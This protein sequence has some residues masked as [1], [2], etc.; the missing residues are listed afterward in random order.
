LNG[1]TEKQKTYFFYTVCALFIIINSLLIA[2]EFFYFSFI[3]FVLLV[4]FMMVY[5]LDK[6]LLL[7][8]FLTPLA[9]RI[10]NPDLNVTMALPTEPMMFAI[11][12]LFIIKLFYD[13]H[14]FDSS[15]IRHPVTIAII[16]NLLWIFFTSL[17]S[18]IPIVSFKFLTARLW[19]V[20]SFFFFGVLLFKDYSNIKRF[21]WLF[22]IPLAGVILYITAQH[23]QNGFDR[24]VGTWIVRPFFNDHTA[25]AAVISLF[26]P[27]TLAQVFNSK[28]M[29]S[30][31]FIALLIF[32]ILI[33]G[34]LLSYSRAG[35]VSLAAAFGIFLILKFKIDYKII[36]SIAVI[37]VGLFF[38]FKTEIIME[39][40]KN[41]QDSSG[42]YAEHVRSISNIS[43]DA[44]NLERLNRWAAAMRM[45]K[46]KPIH[47][48]GPGTYQLVYAP[49]QYSKERTVISTNA[50]DLGN[51]HS[52]Y[53]GPLSESGLPGMI[54]FIF[55]V[56]FVIYTGLKVYKRTPNPE[57]RLLSFGLLLG[58][59]T[60]FTH[61][62]MN[63]FLDTDK[64]SV[65]FWAMIAI[66]VALD[67]YHKDKKY[68][69][70]PSAKH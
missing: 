67:I 44:S 61:G 17:T 51:A 66:L 43:T 36:F 42:Q 62:I 9:V 15:F 52:E 65:P 32:T 26:I 11:L 10:G 60:Y 14:L 13:R 35:W 37:L 7:I 64:A 46:E 68:D 25:Y 57:V 28:N 53:I 48:W 12:L 38:I 19:F 33:V 2:Q 6:L 31:R 22:S 58:L 39:L 41:T 40:E 30:L 18:V 27:V 55:I 3:P 21:L 23:A 47:G 8:A 69:N 16:I 4:G 50:G 1:F 49:F 29:R 54:S 70:T 63:N 56:I 45:F 24:Q 5:Y 20:V 59:I 34:V